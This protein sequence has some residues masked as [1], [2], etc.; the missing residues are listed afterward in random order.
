MNIQTNVK[1]KSILRQVKY[2]I[3][4]M[5]LGDFNKLIAAQDPS[6][7][8]SFIDENIFGQIPA[9]FNG[10][11]A[12]YRAFRE[13]IATKFGVRESDI[14]IVGSGRLGFSYAKQTQFNLDSDIDVAIVN[15]ELFD[16]YSKIL[17]RYHYDVMRYVVALDKREWSRYLEFLKY[18]AAGWLRPDKG[19][20]IMNRNPDVTDWWAYFRSVSHGKSEVGNHRVN[21]GIY[22]SKHYLC[23]YLKIGLEDCQKR[24]KAGI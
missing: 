7:F 10:D 3:R 4:Y 14:Y 8:T 19:T 12:L 17:C 2:N 5:T 11:P 6:D 23:E 1:R 15:E 20:T 18:F 24:M 21:A 22:K 9:V 16:K 13:R